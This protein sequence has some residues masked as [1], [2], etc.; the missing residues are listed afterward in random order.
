MQSMGNQKTGA[1]VSPPLDHCIVNN[2]WTLL[3]PHF[4]TL[5]TVDS[6]LCKANHS[7][8]CCLGSDL[9]PT[10]IYSI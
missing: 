10:P 6:F 1:Q 2:Q 4:C 3:F 5:S 7:M 8:N 9:E